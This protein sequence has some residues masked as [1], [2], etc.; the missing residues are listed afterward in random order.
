M[1]ATA[2]ASMKIPSSSPRL[3]AGLDWSRPGCP[4]HSPLGATVP[5]LRPVRRPHPITSART[6][7]STQPSGRPAFPGRGR[8]GG[9]QFGRY[10]GQCA[11]PRLSRWTLRL[12]STEHLPYPRTPGGG[13]ESWRDVHGVP[14]LPSSS[15]GARST[16]SACA[17]PGQDGAVSG[18][19]ERT[20]AMV[21]ARPVR[22][23]GTCASM[24][25]VTRAC[26]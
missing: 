19:M 23:T 3:E 18:A 5:G 7:G 8:G 17:R 1:V 2:R 20:E 6:R 13:D 21:S 25:S 9:R 16:K 22:T 10:Q 15:R 14:R 11:L 4:H 12:S 24:W 26:Q